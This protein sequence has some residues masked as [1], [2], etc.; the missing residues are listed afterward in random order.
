MIIPSALNS[1]TVSG[2]FGLA[3]GLLFGI[4]IGWKLYHP[5]Q[6]AETY[7]PAIV[8]KNEAVALERKP[9]QPPPAQIKVAA[10]ELGGKLTRTATVVLQPK[11]SINTAGEC[12]CDEITVD[13]GLVDEGNGNRVVVHTDDATV[14]GGTDNPL[15]PYAVAKKMTWEIG[16]I[17]P[18]D[19][20]KGVGPTVA[21]HIGPFKVG[22]AAMRDREDGWTGMVT[23]SISF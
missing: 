7:K 3:L 9:D 13:V 16:V 8:L 4:G 19:Y 22:L 14:V 1:N 10:K 5:E 17:A 11:P 18:V 6:M 2:L 12:K 21:R 20:V 15:E 23:A